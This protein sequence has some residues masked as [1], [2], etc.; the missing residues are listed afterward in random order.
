MNSSGQ[1]TTHNDGPVRIIVMNRP[2]RR[3]AMTPTMLASMLDAISIART[4]RL[5]I[6]IAGEGEAFCAG[7]DMQLVHD[8]KTALA[9]LLI[10]LTAVLKALRRH[11]RPVVVA[12][13]GAAVAGGCALLGGADVAVTDQRATLGY[14]V[15]RLGISPAV[16]GPT[17]VNAIGSGRARERTLDPGLISGL[18]SRRIGLSHVCCDIPEDVLP[19]S[20]RWAKRLAAHPADV[21]E[22]TKAHLNELE[23]SSQDDRF[24]Q[25]LAAS[26]SLLG[27]A[28]QVARVA[29]LWARA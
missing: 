10:G 15:V 3:N 18:E 19:T 9:S 27:T 22:A 12:A 17:L 21:Y 2:Q 5:A 13:H 16:N 14:P 20:V 6:V 29:G 7:F 23:G 26:M 24:A 25:A 28:D 1:I 8:D 4:E 11:P